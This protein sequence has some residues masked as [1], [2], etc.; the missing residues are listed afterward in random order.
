MYFFVL[1]CALQLPTHYFMLEALKS[2]RFLFIIPDKGEK[3]TVRPY[4]NLA[5]FAEKLGLEV[6][7]ID[8]RW[9][10]HNSLLECMLEATQKVHKIVDELYPTE[11]IFFG[12]GIGA[13]TATQL[14]YIFRAKAAMLCSMPALFD[15]EINLL[16]GFRRFIGKKRI[17][18]ARNRPAYPKKKI[19]FPAILLYT[20]KEKKRLL[21]VLPI[22]NQTFLKHKEISIAKAKASLW[23]KKYF[24]TVL[25]QLQLMTT[26]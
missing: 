7:M 14:S 6:Y 8:I 22:R 11:I 15:E 23:N 1:S 24:E 25:E 2:S 13:M 10:K 3:S 21:K 26:Q 16:S 12:F 17:Y 20:E 18:S 19:S 4:R 9:K 5:D